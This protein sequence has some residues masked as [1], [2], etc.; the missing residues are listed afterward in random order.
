MTSVIM[1]APSRWR[2]RAA[3]GASA[4]DR[5]ALAAVVVLVLPGPALGEARGAE[6]A[7][8]GGGGRAGDDPFRQAAADGRRGLE[9]R[10][11]VAQ[12]S[13][14]PLGSEAVDDRPAVGTH[15]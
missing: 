2:R 11:G 12:H 1:L 15:Q 6:R 5:Q 8:V 9:R 3:A 4:R 14:Q 7:E 10:A 13:P